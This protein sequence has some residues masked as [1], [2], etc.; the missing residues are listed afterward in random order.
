MRRK[1]LIHITAVM[2]VT[3]VLKK[4]FNSEDAKLTKLL[5]EIFHLVDNLF[6]YLSF[7]IQSEIYGTPKTK[8]NHQKL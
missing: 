7:P 4:V 1:E 8:C 6:R 5:E 2:M 3:P